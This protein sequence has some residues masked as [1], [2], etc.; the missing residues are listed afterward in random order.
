MARIAKRFEIS[1]T[2]IADVYGLFLL[3]P[4]LF[5]IILYTC[6]LMDYQELQIMIRG[7]WL[8]LP[9]IISLALPGIIIV[10]LVKHLKAYDGSQ[11][12]IENVNK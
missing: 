1:N 3:P 4:V 8:I 10:F 9:M 11:A 7:V 5:C 12:K 6:K 2:A